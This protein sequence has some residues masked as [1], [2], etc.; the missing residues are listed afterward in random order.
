M[1]LL[2]GCTSTRKEKI[3]DYSL[4]KGI[5]Y[6][7]QELYEKAIV[8]YRKAYSLE[9]NNLTLLKEMGYCYYQLGDYKKAEEFWLKGLKVSPKDENI[10]K[11]LVTLYYKEGEYDKIGEI[12][13]RSDNPN[14]DYYLKIKAF[15]L[16]SK[17]DKVEA[18]EILS[19]LD[20]SDFDAEDAIKYMDIL[21]EL[22]K[23]DELYYFMK[24][25]YPYFNSNKVYVINYAQ[26][27]S[28]VYSLDKEAEKILLD[29]ISKNG[30]DSDI[31]TQLN[32]PY[33][34]N[35]S[36]KGVKEIYKMISQ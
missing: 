34:K 3:V 18:Y 27:L 32:S 31:T 24:N 9:S 36:K 17:G 13:V 14:S 35:S 6:S 1:V 23:N 5:N 15:I 29:Y 22:D 21:K 25:T 12:V 4:L 28:S 20:I 33:L 7:Q 26:N 30:N 10:I 16:Y 2:T 8:E 19:K 11:N